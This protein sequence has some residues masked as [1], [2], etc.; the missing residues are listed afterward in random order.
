MGATGPQGMTGF[1]GPVGPQ[2][3]RG[4]IGATG[5]RGPVGPRGA[6]G[7]GGGPPVRE[8]IFPSK[9]GRS[10]ARFVQGDDLVELRA[11]ASSIVEWAITVRP[12]MSM[13]LHRDGK[14]TLMQSW[15][16][17]QPYLKEPEEMVAGALPFFIRYEVVA[18]SHEELVA[19]FVMA[20]RAVMKM[21]AVVCAELLISHISRDEMGE[22]WEDA[23]VLRVMTE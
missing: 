10:V 16:G 23:N 21:I 9:E 14:E 20:K 22:A 7:P 3:A 17:T 18:P 11:R 13:I 4:S 15:D 5:M 8:V 6:T 1:V 2:G 12:H 19:M